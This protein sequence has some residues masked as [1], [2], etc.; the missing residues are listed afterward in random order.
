MSQLDRTLHPDEANQAFTVGKLLETGVYTYR[1][2][3]HHGPTLYY[4]AAPLQRAFGHT[5]TA[6]L[7]PTVLRATPLVFAVAGL[8]F[9]YLAVLRLV[10][11]ATELTGWRSFV[12]PLLPVVLVGSAPLY[13][14]YATDFI[15]EMLL[16]SFTLMM[17]WAGTGYYLPAAKLKRGAWALLFGIGAGLAF[18]T[19]ETCVMTFAS[20]GGAMLPFLVLSNRRQHKPAL[21]FDPEHL[22]LAF[23]GFLLTGVMLFSS[24]GRDFSGVYNAFIAAPGSYV[25]RAAGD[26]V[27]E[28]AS[29]HVH[30]WWQHLQWLFLG[31][32]WGPDK[33]GV[34]WHQFTNLKPLVHWAL[35]LLPCGL[36]AFF[37]K[38]LRPRE[39]S[40]RPLVT[41]FL[42]ASLYTVLILLAYSVIPYKTPWCTLQIL[43]PYLVATSLGY[44]VAYDTFRD[45]AAVR[46]SVPRLARLVVPAVLLLALPCSLVLEHVP[47][48]RLMASKPDAPQIPYNYAHSSPEVKQL[49]ACVAD[50]LDAATR[51]AVG[52]VD[53]EKNPPPANQPFIAVALPSTDTWPFPFYNRRFEGITGYWTKFEDLVALQKQ[54]V[55][56]TVVIV[57]MS[58]GHLAQA[59]FPEL[60]H[61]KRFYMRPGVRVR[62]FW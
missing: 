36:V 33:N 57:P 54:G 31:N 17:F 44:L 32:A 30:P 12:L 41:A 20:F 53:P 9:L 49:A 13:A 21:H 25:H 29:W 45:L 47:G 4:A 60:K 26:A 43:V 61:T 18:A 14:F 6:E 59:L 1:P 42:G 46:R 16:V 7:D 23:A 50:A 55:K 39:H 27:S 3:D 8:V 58:E 38:P 40:P 5:K 35:L 37:R 56:P 15:Q 62:V 22:L 19:K 51:P 48:L 52:P 28:G 10:R 11:R 34:A 2:T 24:F